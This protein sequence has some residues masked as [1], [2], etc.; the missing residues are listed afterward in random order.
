MGNLLGLPLEILRIVID[1][2]I[3]EESIPPID[4]ASDYDARPGP[5]LGSFEG[6]NDEVL[7]GVRWR[8]VDVKPAA[9]GLLVSCKYLHDETTAALRSQFPQG[10]VF[11][12]D[13]MLGDNLEYWPTWT[14]VPAVPLQ[15]QPSHLDVTFRVFEKKGRKRSNI[16]VHEGVQM[17]M[18]TLKHFIQSGTIY[19]TA[20]TF[21][22]CRGPPG[23][24]D[25]RYPILSIQTKIEAGAG[26][27]HQDNT[28]STPY[29]LHSICAQFCFFLCN[30]IK[31]LLLDSTHG[32][33]PI[34]YKIFF[35]QS[36]GSFFVHYLQG[37]VEICNE[38]E[39]LANPWHKFQL[40]QRTEYL[41]AINCLT[42][43]YNRLTVVQKRK[44]LGLPVAEYGEMEWP[45]TLTLRKLRGIVARGREGTHSEYIFD[46]AQRLL[47]D[48]RLLEISA[49]RGF[50]ASISEKSS[51]DDRDSI[52]NKV[53]DWVED[54]AK[55]CYEWHYHTYST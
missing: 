25:V 19:P 55:T 45:T 52:L 27:L 29:A 46:D 51:S 14:K 54:E 7:G 50:A 20:A 11:K 26:E 16:E 21:D 6:L 44:K 1:I 4:M 49:A 53:A 5:A 24:D 9:T 38:K 23:S 17:Y 30:Y 41:E 13:I 28:T 31:E 32:E 3:R 48:T 39:P 35:Q 43:W 15:N 40:H 37:T 12:L 10:I 34:E 33:F 22:P 42:F 36:I 18:N 47:E 2:V 8:K